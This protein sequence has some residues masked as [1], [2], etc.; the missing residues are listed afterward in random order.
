MIGNRLA[1]RVLYRTAVANKASY[2]WSDYVAHLAG[3]GGRTTRLMFQQ[4]ML[5]FEATYAPIEA[6]LPQ[7]TA[8]TLLVWGGR[9]PILRP[10]LGRKIQRTIEGSELK[11][12]DDTG[13][14]VVEEQPERLARDML[15]FFTP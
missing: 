4:T 8:P 15:S 11:V 14:Y 5:E 1:H 6:F 9:D 12:Y 3:A 7:V 13:H 10:S 2:P